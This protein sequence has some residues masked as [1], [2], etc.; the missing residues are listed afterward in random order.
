MFENTF[1]QRNKLAKPPEPGNPGELRDSER[2]KLW[3]V[4]YEVIYRHYA[5][6]AATIIGEKEFSPPVRYILRE[7]WTEYFGRLRDEYGGPDQ[8]VQFLRSQF[9]G[10]PFHVPLDILESV[11]ENNFVVPALQDKLEQGLRSE[12]CFYQLFQGKFI[13]RLPPEQRE[14]LEAALKTSDPIRIHLETALRMLSDRQHPDYRNSIK[15]SILAVEAACK[16]LT[17]SKRGTLNDALKKL[18]KRRP[19]H[20]AFKE[21][22]EKLYAWTGDEDGVRHS[23][24]DAENVESADAQ[25]MLV[26]CS[27]FVNYLLTR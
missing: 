11:I 1:S 14:S 3:N 5:R 6:V 2:K 22:L 23:I 8:M 10:G 16:N 9:L 7:L 12:N 25:F 26:A 13:P 27:A 18:D 24:M 21:A 19:L 15:E 17:G 4:F 20:P